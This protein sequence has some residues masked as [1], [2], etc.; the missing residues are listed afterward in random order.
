[1]CHALHGFYKEPNSEKI[2]PGS[3]VCDLWMRMHPCACSAVHV[4]KHTV[5]RKHESTRVC[6]SVNESMCVM[7]LRTCASKA[8]RVYVSQ[9]EIL[10]ASAA[11]SPTR[12]AFASLAPILSLISLLCPYHSTYKYQ[13]ERTW[14]CFSSLLAAFSVCVFT[15]RTTCRHMIFINKKT[16]VDLM[17]CNADFSFQRPVALNRPIY[18]EVLRHT[19][20]H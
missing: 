15:T 14:P 16:G 6:A 3:A 10:V 12:V 7:I 8:W 17:A 9:G 20:G 13:C 18:L 4:C 5:A 11:D 19:T 2:V 1:M